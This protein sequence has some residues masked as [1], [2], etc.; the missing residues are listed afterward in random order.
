LTARNNSHKARFGDRLTWVAALIVLIFSSVLMLESQ[1]AA[2][3]GSYL[4][5][6]VMLISLPRWIDV[7]SCDLFWFAVILLVYLAV[8][9]LWS[10]ELHA[11][12]VLSVCVR[13]VLTLLFVVAIAESQLRG[14]MQN[15]LGVALSV[16][17]LI[18]A[19]AAFLVH[20]LDPPPDGRLM[21][22][23]QLDNNVIAGLVFAV[24]CLFAM[25]HAIVSGNPVWN[26]IG[27]FA[28]VIL[29]L[30]VFATGSRGAIGSFAVGVAVYWS[31][32]WTQKP[33]QF[34]SLVL[35]MAV[36]VGT[37]G[38]VLTQ[39]TMVDVLFP[40]GDSFRLEIWEAAITKTIQGGPVFG[41]GILTP[42]D[43]QVGGQTIL[44]PHS[45]YVSVFFQGGVVGLILLTGLI[46]RASWVLLSNFSD[47]DAKF[48]LAIFAIALTA[49]LFDEHEL[50]DKVGS[51]WFLFWL[52]VGFAMGLQ[53]RPKPR[54]R[55]H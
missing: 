42:D 24:A 54:G 49:Y 6:L 11:R 10:D 41:L 36:V 13:V 1:S 51:T 46:A 17:G 22:L 18:A 19:C 31:A 45:L 53:W 29:S 34:F 26:K 35:P 52:P 4:L 9:T 16:V 43:F 3:Y 27:W 23:G 21:G 33:T 25:R 30:A 47:A 12:S 44:H 15:A 20:Y 2:S 50:V 32:R 8:S 37:I 7:R 14:L 55:V 48:G 28:V 38:L 39:T 40:R 5:A